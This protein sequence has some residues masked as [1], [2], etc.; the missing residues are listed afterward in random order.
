V[1][2]TDEFLARW[3]DAVAR[4]D[5]IPEPERDA[6]V[7]ALLD[8]GLPALDD[9]HPRDKAEVTRSQR[10]RLEHHVIGT[11]GMF[12]AFGYFWHNPDLAWCLGGH[13]EE[14]RHFVKKGWKELRN[15]NPDFDLWFYWNEYLDPRTEVVNPLVHYL[16]EGRHRGAA[17]LPT[18]ET[19]A[20]PALPEPGWHPRRACLFAA[21]DVD[22][23]VDPT[24]VAYVADLSRFAD[25]YY[26]A[27]C[28]M[29]PGEL[30]KLAPYTK[31]RWA[32]RHGR[33]DFG[34]Y[35]MLAT[36]LV[37]WDA[38]AGYDEVLLTNDSCYLVQPLDRV[39][40]RMDG[41]ACD[42]W[43]LQATYESFGVHEYERLGRPLAI[44][45]ME[46]AMRE[47]RLWR[48]SDF[49]H[50]GS[51]FVAF[52][53]RVLDDPRFRRRL[54]E[55]AAQADKTQIILKYE[56]GFSRLLIL[57]GY[58]LST[59]VDG[60]LPY[61]PV[62]RESAFELLADGFP[63][64]KRQFLYQNPFDAPDLRKWKER[65]L[66][67]VPDADVA[68]MEHNLHRVSPFWS[69]Q[70]SFDIR[71]G[72]DG[73]VHFPESIGPD[74]FAEH[75]EG[76]PRHPHWWVFTVDPRTGRLG[77]A[78]RAV[79]EAVRHD[80]GVKKIVLHGNRKVRLDA[81]RNVVVAPAKSADGRAYALR[82][83]FVFVT[84]G[85]RADLD[86]PLSHAH[87]R[88]V[89]LGNPAMVDVPEPPRDV[90]TQHD[91]DLT[92]VVVVDSEQA[93]ARAS[94]AYPHIPAEALW[95]T[96]N[97]RHDLL[98]KPEHELPP[99]MRSRLDD[100]RD[101]VA[102]RP[103]VVISTVSDGAADRAAELAGRLADRL[104]TDAV[105][106]LWLGVV[107]EDDD[108]PRVPGVV[109][110]SALAPEIEMAWRLARVVVADSTADQDDAAVA[111]A[112]VVPLDHPDPI[113]AVRSHLAQ[114]PGTS[115]RGP[116][117][118]GDAAV[119]VVREARRTYQPIDEWIAEAEAATAR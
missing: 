68:T 114:P 28:E 46:Q 59:Y 82:A 63:L 49:I 38:L 18:V 3:L 72:A 11:S 107:T 116:L 110:L 52:R 94:S 24:V 66:A 6:F 76:V 115:R 81:G 5:G 12:D 10:A 74:N 43:G 42:W 89:M 45:E 119:R 17:P 22:G 64:L 47:L 93:L 40:E 50:V 39:F 33:Y 90:P 57:S 118:D 13:D 32:M 30:D 112:A 83:G 95:L 35:S 65:V 29:E 92:R 101:I 37:G 21:F 99:S 87:R 106:G 80:G 61:H 51:Y 4:Y 15:P 98:V 88:F 71:T 97:P 14:L 53:R 34:S 2:H 27:D 55:V 20:P 48:Y 78:A 25:V 91:L 19:I 86:H 111:T 108:V 7:R 75:E 70:R 104:A 26:L 73:R 77:G 36:E 85:P 79:F 56:I 8:S 1:S 100:I 109:D 69:L 9:S 58:H 67:V 96:G 23:I 102:E 44:D 117:D 113:E 31:G 103:L 54:E 60:V 62:Y 16:V 105:V 41:R 84:V